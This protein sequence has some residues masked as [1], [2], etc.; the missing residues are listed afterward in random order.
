MGRDRR[1]QRTPLPAA[2]GWRAKLGAPL[3]PGE[4]TSGG[5]GMLMR[6]VARE[7][8]MDVSRAARP[9][10]RNPGNVLFCSLLQGPPG[11]T[12]LR[13]LA[14]HPGPAVSARSFVTPWGP[15]PTHLAA[16]SIPR[17]PVSAE[18][19]V[20]MS[21]A[22]LGTWRELF[23]VIHGTGSLPSWSHFVLITSHGLCLQ[24]PLKSQQGGAHLWL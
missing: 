19:F 18:R 13:G 15:A 10:I 24:M 6:G 1:P 5:R 8:L 17:I 11:P 12:G 2:C 23:A 22:L 16:P 4:V 21:L 14:G 3:G 20:A 9:G 7:I